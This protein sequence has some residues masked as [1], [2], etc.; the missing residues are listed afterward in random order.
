MQ[1]RFFAW[2]HRATPPDKMRHVLR[3]AGIEWR[4]RVTPLVKWHQ[5]SLCVLNVP[6]SIKY[7]T[8]LDWLTDL[9]WRPHSRDV[10]AWSILVTSLRDA[11]SWRKVTLKLRMLSLRRK[12]FLDKNSFFKENLNYWFIHFWRVLNPVLDFA[13]FYHWPQVCPTFRKGLWMTITGLKI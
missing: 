1:R 11:F 4:H 12:R 6:S 9:E 3:W 5:V 2:C 13:F 8:S 10:F 7:V